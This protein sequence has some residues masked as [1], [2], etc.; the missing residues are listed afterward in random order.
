VETIDGRGL[1]HENDDKYAS[2]EESRDQAI[3]RMQEMMCSLE[4]SG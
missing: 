3:K 1:K 4:I 2:Y